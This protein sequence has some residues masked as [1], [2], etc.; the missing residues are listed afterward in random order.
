MVTIVKKCVLAILLLAA[1]DAVAQDTVPVKKGEIDGTRYDGLSGIHKRLIE[2]INN[3]K[4]KP[5]DEGK[6]S[7]IIS[8]GIFFDPLERQV[9]IYRKKAVVYLDQNKISKVIF[10]YYRFGM[11]NKVREIKTITNTS[12]ES[13]DLASLQIDYTAN[14]GEKNS[15]KAGDLELRQSQRDI[16]GQYAN[17]LISLIYT[18]ELNK[19]RAARL[20]SL[21]IERTLQLGD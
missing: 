14:T 7:F 20:Q 12:T 16:I 9:C 3:I 15:F 11:D 1:V 6:Y 5:D 4:I 19:H 2:A 8:S 17:Y 10:E 21:Q 18:I 13:D